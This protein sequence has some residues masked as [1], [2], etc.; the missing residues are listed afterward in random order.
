MATSSSRRSARRPSASLLALLTG[1]L[2]ALLGAGSVSAADNP[3]VAPE[4]RAAAITRPAVV[5]LEQLWSGYITDH[6]GDVLND[7]D[8]F[9][10]A[11][12]CTGFVVNP[13]GYIVTAGHCVDR[14]E[15]RKTFI[16]IGAQYW[17]QRGWATTADYDRLLAIGE[18]NWKVEGK[19]KDS[20]IDQAVYVQRGVATS[21][22][23]SGEAFPARVIASSSV[24]AGDVALLKVEQSNMPSVLLAPP[25]E[26]QIGTP[27]LSIGYPGSTD[28][29]TDQ[30]LEPTNKDGKVSA[31]RTLGSVPFYEISAANSGGMSGGP[32]VDLEGR[33]VGLVS[34]G[35]SGESQAFNFIAPSSMI[36]EVLNRNGVKNEL[37]RIDETYRQGLGHYFEGDFDKATASFDQVL[38]IVPSHQQAQEFKQRAAERK[39]TE[40]DGGSGGG[41]IVIAAVGLGAVALVA[42]VVALLAKQRSR[43]PS[44]PPS[45]TMAGYPT[46]QAGPPP[47]SVEPPNGQGP[48]PA[49]MAPTAS[50]G[51]Q[52]ARTAT[53]VATKQTYCSNC[54]TA[55]DAGTKYCSGCGTAQS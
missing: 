43:R 33:V 25:T 39:A 28:E 16:D 50:A 51:T 21:G 48:Q 46:G 20:P 35:P 49:P 44:G 13:A 18:V 3:T 7:G 47:A 54:G 31:K 36:A 17:I 9:E 26:I 29:V 19:A 1:L 23:R 45:G 32:T 52:Q 27:V 4:E 34:F 15:A 8:P 22:L 53:Q 10:F 2:L 30:T 40:G 6:E 24:E 38:A 5:Y 12:R 37:G 41:G 11:T 42:V 14:S 55:L